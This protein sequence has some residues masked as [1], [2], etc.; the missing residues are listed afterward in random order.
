MILSVFITTNK[1]H[2]ISQVL[3]HKVLVL[4]VSR[5]ENKSME[6]MKLLS[7]EAAAAAAE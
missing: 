7:L 2:I 1:Q 3:F 4:Y 5:S 6:H